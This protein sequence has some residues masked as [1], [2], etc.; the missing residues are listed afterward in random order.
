MLGNRLIED[1]SGSKEE[2]RLL[3]KFLLLFK[4]GKKHR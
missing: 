2:I 4:K 1:I 3:I